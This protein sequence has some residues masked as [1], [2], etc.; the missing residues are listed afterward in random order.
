MIARGL[1]FVA[2]VLVLAGCG[3]GPTVEQ[4]RELP[5]FN[6]V[7]ITNDMDVTVRRGERPSALVRV[8]EN[9]LDDVH[10]D[11]RDGT[12][13]VKGRG[14][15]IVIGD[16]PLEDA[17]VTLTVPRL[18]SVTVSGSADLDLGDVS[19]EAFTVRMLGSGEVKATGRVRRL[20]VDISG[21]ADA[22]LKELD[23]D[24]VEVD[25]SGSGNVQLGRSKDLDATVSGSGDISYR[26][27]PDVQSKVSGAGEIGPEDR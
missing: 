20:N 26:G 18:R 25:V 24:R 5:T 17:H 23:A 22:Y 7:W 15:A 12:L 9:A 11:V 21:S 14:E 6:R 2:A 3:A 8:G 10:T 13:K 16:D 27:K 1:V 4:R 19:G